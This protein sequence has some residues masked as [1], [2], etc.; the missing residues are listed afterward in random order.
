MF[1]PDSD[2]AVERQ[3]D[4]F[5]KS[6]LHHEAINHAKELAR[7]REH[8]VPFDELSAEEQRH[9]VT[10][11]TYLSD[12]FVFSFKGYSF[13][14]RSESVA[15]AFSSLNETDQSILILDFV[16]GLN[17]RETA[18]VIGLSRSSV[19]RRKQDALRQLRNLLD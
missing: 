12:F 18:E 13:P 11:D 16:L 9:L 19:Q 1:P 3:F 2:Q 17:D 7:V 10:T 15:N 6:V 14:I 4:S 8:E 5:C